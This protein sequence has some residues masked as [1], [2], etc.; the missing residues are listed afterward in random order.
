MRAFGLSLGV[1]VTSI[2]FTLIPVGTA[3]ADTESREGSFPVPA[4][5]SHGETG[6]SVLLKAGVTYRIA[7]TGSVSQSAGADGFTTDALYCYQ[8]SAPDSP[9]NQHI[10]SART[11]SASPSARRASESRT[12]PR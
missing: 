9:C 7:V 1:L 5:P 3:A 8:G 11:R 2:G 6:S 4:G 12:L 10:R